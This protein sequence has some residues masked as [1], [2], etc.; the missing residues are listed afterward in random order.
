[1]YL[2]RLKLVINFVTGSHQRCSTQWIHQV[3]RMRVIIH[4][5]PQTVLALP[6]PLRI[7]MSRVSA[8]RATIKSTVVILVGLV[9]N[10]LDCIDVCLVSP[11]GKFM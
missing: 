2:T 3:K 9:S 4:V 6:P 5:W 8:L 1:M 11:Y 7:L 10:A